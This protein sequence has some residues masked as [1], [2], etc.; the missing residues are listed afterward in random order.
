MSCLV[1]FKFLP[2]LPLETVLSLLEPL[3]SLV[4][5]LYNGF[6][7]LLPFSSITL[8]VLFPFEGVFLPL[9]DGVLRSG[10]LREGETALT[11]LGGD[12]PA[13]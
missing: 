6:L 1:N 10:D 9:D 7:L 4:L 11:Y 12:F 3:K 5:V 8:L 13:D 2:D